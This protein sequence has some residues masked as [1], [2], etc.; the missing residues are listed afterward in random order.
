[1]KKNSMSIAIALLLTAFLASIMFAVSASAGEK[2]LRGSFQAVETADGAF[3]TAF[4]DGSGS[5]NATHLGQFVFSYE[6]EVNLNTGFGKVSAH[7]VAANG[8][9]L[10]AEGSGQLTPTE[11]PNIAT[12]MEEYEIKD[13]MGRFAGA[14]GSFTV[15]RVL[16]HETGDTSGTIDGKIAMP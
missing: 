8:D 16:N 15:K 4:V 3:P 10:F 13:G 12:I 11:T 5:G 6:A 7:Y 1:M 2:P 9:S 14:T